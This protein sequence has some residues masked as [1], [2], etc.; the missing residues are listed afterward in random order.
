MFYVMGTIINISILTQGHRATTI[1]TNNR[2]VAL[3]YGNKDYNWWL[4]KC[5]KYR[6]N[7]IISNLK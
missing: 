7:F 6:L 1:H 3:N 5:I 2:I 4:N